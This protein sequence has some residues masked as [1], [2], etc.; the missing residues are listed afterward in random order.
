MYLL[1]SLGSVVAHSDMTTERGGGK[2]GGRVGGKEGGRG[3]EG[4]GGREGASERRGRGEGEEGSWRGRRE[5]KRLRCGRV[6]VGESLQRCGAARRRD[7][8]GRAEA[9]ARVLEGAGVHL[10][11]RHQLACRH[12][13]A[14]PTLDLGVSDF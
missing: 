8:L 4:R 9:A 13:H 10:F 5:V 2:E 12:T 14:I 1:A 3:A 11:R 7:A 6:P